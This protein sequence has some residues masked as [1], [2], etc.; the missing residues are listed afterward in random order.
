[1][2][3]ADAP[4]LT[5]SQGSVISVPDHAE[6]TVT[7]RTESANPSADVSNH[8]R[9]HAQ[10]ERQVMETGAAVVPVSHVTEARKLLKK[11]V[12]GQGQQCALRTQMIARLPLAESW[13]F[14]KRVQCAQ[15]L[16]DTL[17]ALADKT[18]GLGVSTVRWVLQD[19]RS[20]ELQANAALA[21]SIQAKAN[22]LGAAIVEIR[23]AA[24]CQVTIEGPMRAVLTATAEVVLRPVSDEP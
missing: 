11:G 15:A 6:V 5:L 19:R 2:M 3:N 22:A 18:N 21:E 4:S 23:P 12:F 14:W 13:S 9:M 10:L 20:G 7:F 24:A 8:E 16:R 17:N 1:M